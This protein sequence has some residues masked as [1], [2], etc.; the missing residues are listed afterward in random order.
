MDLD[1]TLSQHRE[2]NVG[3][4]HGE[5]AARLGDGYEVLRQELVGGLLYCHDRANTN[6]GKVLE[7]TSFAYALIELLAEKGLLTIAE[8]DARKKIV[9]KRLVEKLKENG[10]GVMLQQEQI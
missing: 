2:S 5:P 7:V 10:M 9:G 3:E 4:P 1:N 6:T 8:L